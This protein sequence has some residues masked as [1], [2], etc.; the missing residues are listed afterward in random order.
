MNNR[1]LYSLK[2]I[3]CSFIILFGLIR[4][5]TADQ[6]PEY[7]VD[8]IVVIAGRIPMSSSL[9]ARS[10]IVI[11]RDEIEKAPVH[12]IEDLLEYVQGI[13][14]NTR[15]R[16]G[17]QADVGIRG[18]TFEQTLV[19]VDGV[20]MSDPQTGHHNLNLPIPLDAVKRVE[21][22]KGQG[23]GLYGPNAIGGV[24]NIITQ[25]GADKQSSIRGQVGDF[26]FGE[27]AASI[28]YPVGRTG[29]H[30]SLSRKKS[31]GYTDATDFDL[32]TARFGASLKFDAGAIDIS[33]G[34]LDKEFGA[35]RFY[36]D[37]FINEREH[38][39]TYMLN[40]GLTRRVNRLNLRQKFYWRRHKDDFILDN[41]RPD[42]YRNRHTS[43]IYG[44]ES[45][46]DIASAI[47]VTAIG[48]EA[49]RD[50]INSSSL[51]KHSRT[52]GGFFM[53]H[54]S[55]ILSRLILQ[56]SAFAYYYSDWGWQV[57]PALNV[58]YKPGDVW[59][60]F[61]T[62]GRAFRV[63]TYTELY[64]TSPAN[65]GNPNLKPE[66]A[67]TYEIG[68]E[69]TGRLA[70]CELVFFRREGR[71]LIDWAR[72]E[73]ASPGDPWQVLNVSRMNTN[74]I[75]FGLTAYPG[76]FWPQSRLLQIRA[77]YSLLDSDRKTESYE[78][79]YLLKQL[80]HQFLL[81][82][83]HSLPFKLDQTWKLKYEI[84]TVSDERFLVDM[85]VSREFGKVGW[86]IEA[87]N[88][89]NESYFEIGAIPMPGRQVIT[90]IQYK[91]LPRK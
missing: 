47:G 84:P 90:G 15:G 69:W 22:L 26:E 48:G 58:G 42:W 50:E 36:S 68:A 37:N 13:E 53:E 60:T 73:S 12:S 62:I 34:Y 27:A 88:L 80:K 49:G 24:I 25:D 59:R 21:I 38:T 77:G 91:L 85:K 28:S 20:K 86:F 10:V 11:A 64:Y 76:Q 19:L 29:Y 23:S 75:E 40:L 3:A 18:G 4:I 63:P 79:K 32:S 52:R 66:E 51:G 83:E 44:F 70:K 46:A 74:G 65:I 2:S 82:I 14:I 31:G 33:Y 43:D 16:H 71:K 45:Q 39:K 81:N 55:L 9:L 8:D 57:W 1:K 56:T 78:S 67:I 35:N 17:V 54:Q 30:L 61:G 41:Y 72:P 89:F 87:A 5:S 7:K 6:N